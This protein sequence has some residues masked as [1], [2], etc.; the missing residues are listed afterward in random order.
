MRGGCHL[1]DPP[2]PDDLAF[3]DSILSDI[4][5]IDGNISLNTS[6]FSEISP[7]I[8]DSFSNFNENYHIPVIIFDRPDQPTYL[9]LPRKYKKGNLI[10][11]KRNN[12]LLEASNLPVVLNLN[13]RSLYNKQT[14]FCTLIEQTEAT[15]CCISETW[16]RSHYG[17][18]ALISDLIQIEGYRWVKNVV[19]RNRKGG[20]PA[21]LA[22]EKDYY[23]KALSPDIITVPINVE[24]VWILMTPKHRSAQSRIKHIAVASVYYS[25]TQT[26]KSDFL[27]HIS[28]AYTILCAKYGSDLKFLIAG[29]VNRLNIKPIL[30]LSPD[31]KQV[32]QIITRRNPDA[33]LDVIITNLQSFY[34]PPTTLEP[35]DNDATVTGKPSDHLIVKMSP[36]TNQN[37]TQIKR[38]KTIKFRP[39]PDSAIREM[40][41]W[42]QSQ[43]WQEIYVLKDANLKAEL[44]ENILM[45]KINYF[46]PEKSI[47]VSENDKPWADA[48]LLKLDRQCKR[49]YNKKKKSQKW[50]ELYQQF[51]EKQNS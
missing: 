21:I 1:P 34:H 31:L 27:D 44:F 5:Q 43:S 32:V 30:S 7:I 49:E 14:E 13:P 36:L 18:G 9:N 33:T 24:A 42:V 35:L 48:E 4:V 41:K 8:Y 29:D 10:T 51:S 15:L 45:E 46:F 17:G 38:Y 23:I 6:I 50:T 25:S 39:F 26:K 20:K 2:Q 22:S 37:P 16:D 3:N 47:K 19:Q 28:E 40:G 11:I 12:K